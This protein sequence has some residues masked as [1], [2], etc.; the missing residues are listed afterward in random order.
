MKRTAAA[1]LL[2]M[3][4][5]LG[6]GQT[7]A[8]TATEELQGPTNV[9]A[10]LQRLSEALPGPGGWLRAIV[11][12]SPR[13]GVR[14]SGQEVIVTTAFLREASSDALAAGVGC[15]LLRDPVYFSITM[16]RAGFDGP[17]G[18]A[19]LNE[20]LAYDTA[21]ESQYRAAVNV[22]YAEM[23]QTTFQNSFWIFAPGNDVM[24]GRIMDAA[25]L[26]Y[27]EAL[28][29]YEAYGAERPDLPP[30]TAGFIRRVTEATAALRGGSAGVS[31]YWPQIQEALK[32]YQPRR[33][34]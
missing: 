20:R 28:A 7:V 31:S 23:M 32:T 12:S 10:V 33:M 25:T 21:I 19:E 11:V 15:Q 22:A 14:V 6:P 1:L 3:S 13:Y 8:Q 29:A 27:Y 2:A 18:L 9:Y 24:Y 5:S 4:V 16:D 34:E 17:S 30:I 26:R